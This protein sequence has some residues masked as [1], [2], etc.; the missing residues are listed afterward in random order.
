MVANYYYSVLVHPGRLSATDKV[1]N[2]NISD[3]KEQVGD[4]SEQRDTSNTLTRRG[5]SQT[6]AHIG[7]TITSELRLGTEKHRYCKKCQIVTLHMDH[8]C[9][10]TGN[11]VGF[12]TYSHFFLC[13]CYASLGM[14]YSLAVGCFYFG[15]CVVPGVWRWMDLKPLNED[16]Y[17]AVEPFAELFV[18]AVGG[19]IVLN[20]VLGFQVFLLL[21]DMTTFEV[22]LYFRTEPLLRIGWRRIVGKEFLK[23]E[24]RLNILLLSQRKSFMW[25]LI[26]VRNVHYPIT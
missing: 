5:L 12:N 6:E 9:P 20:I 22:L 15:E 26:P 7:E 3:T 16:T 1:D 13:L 14:G 11:C 19:C 18:P 17:A 2:I 23:K 4:H 24:S 25:Y 21:S 10:F 8:H